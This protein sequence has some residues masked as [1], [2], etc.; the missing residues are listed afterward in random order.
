MQKRRK[1]KQT[2]SRGICDRNGRC[3]ACH[4]FYFCM[5]PQNPR[6]FAGT[7][8]FLQST[9]SNSKT[10][11]CPV[12]PKPFMA[13]DI[14]PVDR[15][16]LFNPNNPSSPNNMTLPRLEPMTLALIPF[17]G[18]GPWP[19]HLNTN[20]GPVSEAKIFCYIYIKPPK[21][22]KEKKKRKRLVNLVTGFAILRIVESAFDETDSELERFVCHR[23]GLV[24][25]IFLS[26]CLWR[27]NSSHCFWD[28][29]HLR[30]WGSLFSWILW[31]NK[32]N[33]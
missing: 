14:A 27:R 31:V 25:G 26:F 29:N 28:P 24:L 12:K 15:V 20:W 9:T 19:S 33:Q 4:H 30:Q 1:G 8:T 5:M 22:K 16:A 23:L 3:I 7:A 32:I 18:S 11:W 13:F 21:K 6:S 10:N 2:C 17:L